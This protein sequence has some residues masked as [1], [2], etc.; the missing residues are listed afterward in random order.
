MQDSTLSE[1]LDHFTGPL[2]LPK[3]IVNS[4]RCIVVAGNAHPRLGEQLARAL[5]VSWETPV[6]SNFADGE[7]RIH[8]DSD[9]RDVTA[10]LV[11]PTGPPVNDNLLTLAL[12][13]DACRS[14]GARRVVAVVPYLGYAR[15]DQRRA[16]GDA[17]SAQVVAKLLDAVGVDH[18]ITIDLHSGAL[19]SA[20]AMPLTDIPASDVFLPLLEDSSCYDVVVSPDAGGIKRAQS[21]AR[22][23]QVP[24]A[25]VGKH[26]VGVDT[27]IAES[28]LGNV[29]G[30]CLIVDDMAS[31]GRTVVGAAEA[32]LHAGAKSVDAMLTHAV[33]APGALERLIQSP[34][35]RI[36]VSDS[37]A[38]P[39]T[40]ER[41]HI[42]P[43]STVIASALEHLLGRA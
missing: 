26:R 29:H 4:Q 38:L 32:L 21:F 28:V 35:D 15:Q 37:L 16:V 43:V 3:S 11:Q 25:V 42:Q 30:R 6:I 2:A 18:L 14:A 22:L 40:T 17:R 24:L 1:E 10:V 13:T 19:E 31:T 8:V 33:M 20:F 12:L 39:S 7:T 27:P 34:I 5:E 36:T 9:L 23:L 41:L